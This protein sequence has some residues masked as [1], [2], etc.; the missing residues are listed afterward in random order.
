MSQVD[1]AAGGPGAPHPRL[2][3]GECA[4]YRRTISQ[5]GRQIGKAVAKRSWTIVGR[6]SLVS[7]VARILDFGNTLTVYN[8]TASGAQ[9]DVRAAWADWRAVGNDLWGALHAY[10]DRQGS[11]AAWTSRSS[12]PV[13]ATQLPLI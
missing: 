10:E 6:P 1:G 3:R 13:T 4:C 7:G 8:P 12:K 9:A 11:D 2:V 5:G